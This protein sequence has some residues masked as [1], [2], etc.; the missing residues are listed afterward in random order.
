M[1]NATLVY[2]CK[3][4]QDPRVKRLEKSDTDIAVE[5]VRK[6]YRATMDYN[7]RRISN[8]LKPL[9]KTDVKFANRI[10]TE[11]VQGIKN[12][13]NITQKNISEIGDELRNYIG[14]DFNFF[15]TEGTKQVPIDSKRLKLAYDS[16]KTGESSEKVWNILVN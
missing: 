7:K 13:Q 10:T 16:M 9:Y 14:K 8:S 2:K 1:K 15:R 4:W 6:T 3:P 5:L 12:I 11:V